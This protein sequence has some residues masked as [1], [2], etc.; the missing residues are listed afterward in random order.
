MFAFLMA[1]KTPNAEGYR[2]SLKWIKNSNSS[3]AKHKI[4]KWKTENI[5]EMRHYMGFFNNII[6]TNENW[7][8]KLSCSNMRKMS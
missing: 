4:D 7:K 2:S 3:T 5:E 6:I 1:N 8:Q